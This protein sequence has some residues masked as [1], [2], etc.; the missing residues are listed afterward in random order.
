VAP[1]IVLVVVFVLVPLIRVVQVSFTTWDGVVPPKAV[2]FSN[3]RYLLHW[4]DFRTV[5]L[6][7]AILLTGV[8]LWVILPFLVATVIYRLR[9]ADL[10]RL[11]IF[12]PTI[13]PPIVVGE[14]FATVLADS[15]PVNIALRHLGVGFLAKDWLTTKYLVLLSVIWMI[16]WATFGVGVQFFSAALAAIPPSYVEAAEIDG[17]RWD[18]LV[19][20]VYRPILRPV[21]QFWLLVL[22]ISTLTSFFPWILALT[23]G[24]PGYDSTTLDYE[25]YLSGIVNGEY[26]L[27]SAIAVV[28][29]LFLVILLVVQ[30]AVRVARRAYA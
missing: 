2:G 14:V 28:L 7:N 9:R 5:L 4:P 17:A 21:L 20:D 19:R 3:Y 22:T 11:V 6:N 26:G 24:G 1:V 8:A 29:L 30:A 13:L 12:V 23:Q 10:V 25:V 16:A 27:G 15:G 18:Q